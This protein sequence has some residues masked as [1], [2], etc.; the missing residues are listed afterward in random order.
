MYICIIPVFLIYLINMIGINFVN[1]F[2]IISCGIIHVTYKK[3]HTHM[4][5]SH[6]TAG[7]LLLSASVVCAQSDRTKDKKE[8]ASS[9][10]KNSEVVITK[11]PR[12]FLFLKDQLRNSEGKLVI[13]ATNM[14]GRDTTFCPLAGERL[15]NFF[16]GCG[17][18]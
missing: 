3:N 11:K 2:S 12:E 14:A 16:Y 8:I 10:K 4:K 1:L 17:I 18:G 6:L 5:L 9:E 7:A 13:T 15:P